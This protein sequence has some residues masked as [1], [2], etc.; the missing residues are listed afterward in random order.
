ML[1]ANVNVS[2]APLAVFPKIL[3][4]VF[5]ANGNARVVGDE[6]HARLNDS[7]THIGCPQQV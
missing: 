2:Y 5:N 4:T 7:E 6:L 3:E 1:V